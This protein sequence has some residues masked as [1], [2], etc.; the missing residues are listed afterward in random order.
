MVEGWSQRTGAGRA[1]TGSDRQLL[2]EFVDDLR[3]GRDHPGECSARLRSQL[4][5]RLPE[6]PES[7]D[8][9][10][11]SPASDIDRLEFSPGRVKRLEALS[12][13]C[14]ESFYPPCRALIN[15]SKSLG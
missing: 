3:V 13:S 4:A 7:V 15:R 1:Q 8:P 10:A 9:R 11:G 12:P 14:L 2:C 6:G 5:R